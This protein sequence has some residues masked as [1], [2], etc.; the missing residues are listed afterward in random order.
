VLRTDF[1]AS[2]N[3]ERRPRERV[4]ASVGVPEGPLWATL[5]TG[6]RLMVLPLRACWLTAAFA[7]WPSVPAVVEVGLRRKAWRRSVIAE[8]CVRNTSPRQ[9]CPRARSCDQSPATPAK[10]HQFLVESPRGPVVFVAPDV[11]R[12]FPHNRLIAD[13]AKQDELRPR[14]LLGSVDGPVR[15]VQVD[16][17]VDGDVGQQVAVVLELEFLVFPAELRSGLLRR[18]PQPWHGDPTPARRTRR[19]ATRAPPF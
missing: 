3:Q 10:V 12:Q 17:G 15:R 11:A 16:S 18:P 13:D 1:A 6:V 4:S 2:S 14:K 9:A 8:S 7:A 19:N 5:S